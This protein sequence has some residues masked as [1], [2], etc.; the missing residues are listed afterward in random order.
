MDFKKYQNLYTP[1]ALF[2]GC[3]VIALAVYIRG[4][5]EVSNGEGNVEETPSSP[6]VEGEGDISSNYSESTLENLAKCLTKK[7]AT[8]YAASTC[9]FCTKQKELFG[10]AVSF[11][12]EVECYDPSS[13]QG[14]SQECQD[15][16]ITGVPTWIFKD[17]STLRGFTQ[18]ADLAEKSGCS[19]N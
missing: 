4:G 5:S 6:A 7:G 17:G 3:V 11:L 10:S 12:K 9:S 18:L 15:A 8:L 1:A 16:G 13:T 2:L 19:L 14:W